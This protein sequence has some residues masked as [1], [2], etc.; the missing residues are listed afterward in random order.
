MNGGVPRISALC[1]YAHDPRA[2]ADFWAALLFWQI[3]D[4]YRDPFDPRRFVE[5]HPDAGSGPILRLHAK[6][7][8]RGDSPGAHHLHLASRSHADHDQT[9]ARALLLGATDAYGPLCGDDDHDAFVDPEGNAF[10][11][12]HPHYSAPVD[13]GL[14]AE[15]VCEGSLENA[16]FW[17]A[18]LG[19]PL[20]PS[21]WDQRAT[22]HLMDAGFSISWTGEE[23]EIAP[24]D[25]G[26][27]AHFDL[28]ASEDTTQAG[29]QRRHRALGASAGGATALCGAAMAD[30]DGV[31]YFLAPTP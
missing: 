31:R 28:E 22:I 6:G 13:A 19:A 29:E 23:E 5:I 2:L 7:S 3:H 1:W 4:G 12:L 16:R 21:G 17:S 30:P 11:V 26:L 10:C 20:L 15:V 14:L 24:G 9:V 27:Q 18:I 25:S 8:A